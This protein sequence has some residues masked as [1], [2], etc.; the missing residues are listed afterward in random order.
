MDTT[1]IVRTDLF[2][3]KSG[4]GRIYEISEQT[5]QTKTT[6][7]DG[8]NMGWIEGAKQYKVR[9]GGSASKL[10]QTEFHIIASGEDAIRI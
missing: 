9:S 8:S 4:T 2:E 3:V 6:P 5:T 1:R 7:A 10:S